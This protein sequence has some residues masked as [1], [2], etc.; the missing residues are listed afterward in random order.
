MGSDCPNLRTDCVSLYT[1]E[2]ITMACSPLMLL[3]NKL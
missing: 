2:R 3:L 1:A